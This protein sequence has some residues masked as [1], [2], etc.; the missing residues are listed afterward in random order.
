MIYYTIP[1]INQIETLLQ[2]KFKM[3]CH[4]KRLDSVAQ[5]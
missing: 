5:W 3:V 4:Q 2:F 1:T